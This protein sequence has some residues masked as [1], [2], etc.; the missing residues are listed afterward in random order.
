MSRNQI[1]LLSAGLSTV[2]AISVCTCT[3][4]APFN[5]LNDSSPAIAAAQTRIVADK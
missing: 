5:N 4:T 1:R 3:H 2:F